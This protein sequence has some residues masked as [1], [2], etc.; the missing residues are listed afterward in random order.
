LS[1]TV[2]FIRKLPPQL[3]ESFKSTL[4]ETREADVLLHVVDAGHAR[5]EDHMQVVRQ[6]LAELGAADKPTLLVFNKVD[7]LADRGDL[8]A[9]KRGYP[10]AVF[11][12]ALRGIGLKALKAQLV[13]VAESDF[14]ERAALLPVEESRARAHL[15]RV[16]EVLDEALVTA[17]DDGELIPAVKLRYRVGPKNAEEISRMLAHFAHLRYAGEAAQGGDGSTA[18][19]AD[20][21]PDGDSVPDVTSAGRRTAA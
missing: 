20:G 12:S 19:I 2:G 15:H 14:V 21:A 4:D 8:A 11:V 7:V 16:A 1:D 6:T 10:D 9:M 18:L 3:V 5:F 13:E 17:E